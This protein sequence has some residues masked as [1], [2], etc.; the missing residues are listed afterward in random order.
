MWF[1]CV[2]C[3]KLTLK[4]LL[5]QICITGRRKQGNPALLL[6]LAIHPVGRHSQC[7]NHRD[8]L[9]L[10]CLSAALLQC[11]R[12][13]CFVHGI[14]LLLDR[15][16]WCDRPPHFQLSTPSRNY[17]PGPRCNTSYYFVSCEL[18]GPASSALLGRLV[19]LSDSNRCKNCRYL[20][21]S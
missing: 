20:W 12:F 9:R 2:Y 4:M 10:V 19:V 3:Q 7:A 8:Y 15:S 11:F 16:D 21:N 17:V 14:S 18:P 6:L 1:N 5:L 13:T